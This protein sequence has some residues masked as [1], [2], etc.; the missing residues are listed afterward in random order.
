ML[1]SDT[2][3]LGL[4][5]ALAG[6]AARQSAIAMNLANANTPG[7]RRKD[8]NFEDSLRDAFKSGDRH[9]LEQT[10]LMMV[11]DSRAQMRADG[12]TTDIDTEAAAQAKNGLQYNAIAS[13]MKT[14][15]AIMRSALG[16]G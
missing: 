14:R 2:T 13:V 11:D 12:S 9:L 5:R 6:A 3:Q 8:V 16:I 1:I 7:Y 10:S 4:E 15:T